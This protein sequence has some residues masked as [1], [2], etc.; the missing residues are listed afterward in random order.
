VSTITLGAANYEL[1]AYFTIG[2]L[3]ELMPLLG[4]AAASDG[5]EHFVPMLHIALKRKY[6]G[7][8]EQA[9]KDS[10]ANLPQLRSAVSAIV[11]TLGISSPQAA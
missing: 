6:P 2:E 10:E 1:P 8:T 3:G 9:L 11:T 7:L 4:K 5:V